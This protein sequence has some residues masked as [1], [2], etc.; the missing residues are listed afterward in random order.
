MK[1]A[2]LDGKIICADVG[3]YYED[4]R[5]TGRLKWNRTNKT[6]EGDAVLLTLEALSSCCRLPPNIQAEY[7]KLRAVSEKVEAQRKASEPVLLTP[8]PVKNCELMKHQIV[9]VNMALLLFG[10]ADAR[11]GEK[12]G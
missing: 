9:G 2:L 1:I 3:P 7:D 4:L 11:G 6:M 8:V 5:A 10:A 12:N